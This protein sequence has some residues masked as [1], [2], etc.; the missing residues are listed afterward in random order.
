MDYTVIGR[1]VNLAS[2]L[3]SE[4]KPDQTLVSQM[5]YNLVKDTVEAESIGQIEM[6]GFEMPM[7]VYNVHTIS[8]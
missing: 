2:R 6:K 4:A 8:D 5:T 7:S 3:E 1:Y